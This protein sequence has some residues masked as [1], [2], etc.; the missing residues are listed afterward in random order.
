[1]RSAWLLGL[2]ALVGGGALGLAMLEDPG[3]VLISWQG[4]ALETSLWTALTLVVVASLLLFVT[5]QLLLHLVNFPAWMS[6]WSRRRRQQRSAQLLSQGTSELESGA[7]EKA[8]RHLFSAASLAEYPLPAYLAAARAAQHLHA[9]ERSQHY[10]QLAQSGGLGL[11]VGLARARLLIDSDQWE[12]AAVALRHLRQDYP[13]DVEAIKLL[14]RVLAQLGLWGEL[15]D[16]LPILRQRARRQD[17]A[18]WTL[19]RH[20]HSQVLA[21]IAASG[22]VINQ[23]YT[24]KRL[25]DYFMALPRKLRDHADITASYARGLLQLNDHDTAELLLRERLSL[26]IKDELVDIY[27]CTISSHPEAALRFAESWLGKAPHHAGLM[28]ALGR[29]CLQNRQFSQA[30]DYFE[31]AVALRRDPETYAEL[32]RLLVRMNDHQAQRYLIDGL[33]MLT[34]ELPKLPLP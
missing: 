2:L 5:L 33:A 16:L 4:S 20:A 3:Y 8:E 6:R 24:L 29:L 10:L 32:V 26:S 14:L 34:H 19:E 11:P 21:H 13:S 9:Y 1:M 23:A 25:R 30:R 7:W 17:D 28:R 31:S 18:A 15:A 22:T 12:L 27:G